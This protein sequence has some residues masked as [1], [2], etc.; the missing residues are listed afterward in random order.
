MQECKIFR[1]YSGTKTENLI[2]RFLFP[3]LEDQIHP[4]LALP[5]S[6]TCTAQHH[7]YHNDRYLCTVI[8]DHKELSPGAMDYELVTRL[9]SFDTCSALSSPLLFPAI[10]SAPFQ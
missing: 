4:A 1:V 6:I 9:P 8:A 10:T 7:K 5:K 3:K 2:L